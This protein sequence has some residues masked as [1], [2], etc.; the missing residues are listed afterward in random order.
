MHIWDWLIEI[1]I[2]GS[3]LITRFAVERLDKNKHFQREKINLK[4][5]K[6]N[7]SWAVKKWSKG[8]Y[9]FFGNDLTKT[10]QT[11]KMCKG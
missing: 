1:V 8:I 3:I 10:P 5:V 7:F 6:K 9:Y 2:N 11:K 4:I